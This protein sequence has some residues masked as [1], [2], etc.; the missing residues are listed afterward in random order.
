MEGVKLSLKLANVLIQIG[1]LLLKFDV[2]IFEFLQHLFSFFHH[3]GKLLV[4]FLLVLDDTLLIEQVLLDL[5][6]FLFL[7]VQLG[8]A[9]LKHHLYV[10]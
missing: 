9:L 10:V 2:G 4:L 7:G 6:D 5:L 3:E 8:V 1:F